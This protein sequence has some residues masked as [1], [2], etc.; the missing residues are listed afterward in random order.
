MT[1]LRF[2]P[3]SIG[4]MKLVNWLERSTGCKKLY[5]AAVK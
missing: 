3:T 5:K 2:N 4:R 1:D